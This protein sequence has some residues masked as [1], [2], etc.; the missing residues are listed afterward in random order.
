MNVGELAAYLTLDDSQFNAGL[1]RAKNGLSGVGTLAKAAGQTA[2]TA[3]T[4]GATAATAMAVSLVKTGV[5]YNALQ[6]NSRAALTTLLGSQTAVNA[7]MAKLNELVSRSP[8]GKDVFIQAQ[9]QLI[10]FGM[11]A[12]KV[13]PTL[14]A[15]QNAVAA[16]GGSSQQ[17]SEITFVLAQIQAAGKITGQDLM[18]L[19]QR[20]IDAAT[21]MGNSLGKS[22]AQ[23]RKDITA[24]SLDAGTAI[25]ALVNGMTAKF[26]GATDL[27]KRQWSGAT[28]RI[29]AAWRDTG[30]VLAA[31]FIDPNGGGQAVVW[32]NLVADTMRTV[33]GHVVAAMRV[34]DT[35]A[36]P[37]FDR[38][39]HGLQDVN[40]TAKRFDITR[41]LS[42]VDTLSQYAPLIAGATTALTVLG[43]K[44]VP[45]IGK[46]AEGMTPLLVGVA[47]LIASSPQL[48]GVGTAFTDALAPAVPE[49]KAA[50]TGVADLAMQAIDALAPGLTVAA[51]GA[52]GFLRDL[53]PLAPMLVDTAGAV[54]PL[55]KGVSDLAGWVANLPTPLLAAATAI[56]AFHAPLGAVKAGL[57]GLGGVAGDA[58]AGLSLFIGQAKQTGVIDAAKQSVGGLSGVMAALGGPVGLVGI[59]L[60]AL[61]GIVVAYAAKQAEAKA[62]VDDFTQALEASNGVIDESI[63]K[64]AYD[65]IDDGIVESFEKIGISARDLVDYM[66]GVPEAVD[67]VQSAVKAHATEYA[68]SGMYG[69]TS[70]TVKQSNEWDNSLVSLDKL[71]AGFDAG[72][73]GYKK[74]TTATEEATAAAKR[75]REALDSLTSAMEKQAGA[76]GDLVA[77]Q[78]AA[79]DAID[80][81]NKLLEDGTRIHRNAKGAIDDYADSTR[82]VREQALSMAQSFNTVSEDAQKAGKTQAELDQI[83]QG[84]YDSF[85]KFAEAA[86]YSAD[87]AKALATEVGLIPDRKSVVIDM[88]VNSTRAKTDVKDLINRVEDST[89]NITIDARTDPAAQKLAD[90]LGLV[91]DSEG[92]YSINAKD[93]EALAVLFASLGLV[94]TSTG[95][96]TL[97]GN[98][99]E[100][101]AKLALALRLANGSTGTMSLDG[102]PAQWN[103]KITSALRQAGQSTGVIGIGGNPSKFNGALGSAVSRLNASS[104]A[105]RID[106]KDNATGTARN[107]VAGINAMTAT[108]HV[109]AVGSGMT[110]LRQANGG[111]LHFY[112]DGGLFD[113]RL[114]KAFA[115]G[116]RE[117]HIAQFAAAGAM[118]L[119]AEPETG[120]E[121]YIPLALSKRA[122]S[123]RVLGQVAEEFDG[124]YIPARKLRGYADGGVDGGGAAASPGGPVVSNIF[125]T[126]ID[127]HDL[128]GLRSVEQF[129]RRVG[130][131]SKMAGVH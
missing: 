60:T 73:E 126:T 57:S 38:I 119:W 40:V 91:S 92:V 82:K 13:V 12:E 14:D 35:V 51:Q 75:Q 1:G 20:G 127:A 90:S 81:G 49:L 11:A 19:G 79:R 24:G 118:R 107:I 61:T 102:N 117:N 77:A 110:G 128:D 76:N 67:K 2:A 39:T 83:T 131:V 116:G 23:I 25:D 88:T 50:A 125:H 59:G 115:N 111:I 121:A 48:R 32:A 30:S 5:S 95:T 65:K 58:A 114:V 113:P 34:V 104:G 43:L 94:N 105:V 4:V 123:E 89:G 27:I 44:P 16:T 47:A 69:M 15:V 70:A 64:T 33:Q 72:V 129:V 56:V 108:I 53:A 31:P 98:N 63:R 71:K 9:Q 28:D 124:A 66:T 42:Q 26:G 36:G 84:N 80:A 55:V 10:S 103:G 78:Y 8:F 6:Q 21:L 52:G 86:G 3:F 130:M 29:K 101:N 18:Q 120:G 54:V 122:R 41:I 74:S 68:S 97:D 99:A 93:Q 62:T 37:T 7:Q 112:K 109:G 17:L 85:L 106:A 100:V 87:E 45:Y 22:G 46:L 96:I